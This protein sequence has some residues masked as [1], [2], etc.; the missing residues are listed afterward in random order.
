MET[1]MASCIADLRPELR[2]MERSRIPLPESLILHILYISIKK[3]KKYVESFK[4]NISS[5]EYAITRKEH[6][7]FLA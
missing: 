3:Y 5:D 2:I 6:F 4:Y 7:R 1:P